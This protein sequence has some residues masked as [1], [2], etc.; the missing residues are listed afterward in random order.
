MKQMSMA[1]LLLYPLGASM[2]RFNLSPKPECSPSSRMHLS[3]TMLGKPG[4]VAVIYS[5]PM[6]DDSPIGEADTA[7]LAL[8]G[9]VIASG[10]SG[11]SILTVDRTIFEHWLGIW[12]P[13]D[14]P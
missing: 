13:R 5:L 1:M 4:R 2:Q 6:P 9:R 3:V 10:R 12:E 14:H 7:E 11:G 8:S